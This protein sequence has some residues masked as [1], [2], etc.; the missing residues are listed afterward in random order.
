[1]DE[2]AFDDDAKRRYPSSSP[3]RSEI[4]TTPEAF[5]DEDDDIDALEFDDFGED[6]RGGDVDGEDGSSS[7]STKEDMESYAL[8]LD[9]FTGEILKPPRQKARQ[10][11]EWIASLAS[12]PSNCSGRG[13]GSDGN[14]SRRREEEVS[15]HRMPLRLPANRIALARE[16]ARMEEGM[17][18]HAKVQLRTLCEAIFVSPRIL[19][20]LFGGS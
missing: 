2:Y 4:S 14:G 6:Y 13:S 20:T 17:T 18:A 12:L 1:M 9:D 8:Q 11:P 5:L 15:L 19:R 7:A 16:R 10:E 3:Q